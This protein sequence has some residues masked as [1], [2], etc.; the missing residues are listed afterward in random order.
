M[1]GKDVHVV[2]LDFSKAFGTV[3]PVRPHLEYRVQ[4]W[5]ALYKKDTEVL[6][7]VQRRATKL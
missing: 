4:F 7:C 5:A 3:S 2:Y 1:R 6:E